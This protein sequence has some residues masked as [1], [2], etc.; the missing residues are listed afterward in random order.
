MDDGWVKMGG[1]GMGLE[2]D[3]MLGGGGG[4]EG[5]K[6]GVGRWVEIEGRELGREGW[7]GRS[8]GGRKG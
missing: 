1:G 4:K 5:G 7:S 6:G 3:E 8:W 2:W